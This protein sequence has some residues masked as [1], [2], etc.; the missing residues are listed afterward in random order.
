MINI[1]DFLSVYSTNVK[2]REGSHGEND[3]NKLIEF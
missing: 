2:G 1:N 3:E